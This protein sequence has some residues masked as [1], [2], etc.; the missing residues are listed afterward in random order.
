V[1]VKGL[2]KLFV[3]APVVL[4]VGMVTPAMAQTEVGVGY[5]WQHLS[6]SG[7]EGVNMPFG[8][9]FDVGGRVM[10]NLDVIGQVDWSR[11]S[12]SS[13]TENLT[14]FGGGIRWNA[15]TMSTAKPFI[16]VLVGAAH[17]SVEG[18]SQTKGMIQLGGGVAFPLNA[19]WSGVGQID[20]RR[21]FT[22][23]GTNS[24]RLVFGVR[25]SL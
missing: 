6:C 24:I 15:A 16:D 1:L 4:L 12:E 7:C 13:V 22:D 2:W 11:K 14:A 19:K 9:N 23:P 21:F 8:L 20:Y 17:D 3:A 18:F 25:T 10:P 5:Q